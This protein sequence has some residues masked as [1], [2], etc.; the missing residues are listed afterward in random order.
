MKVNPETEPLFDGE[1]GGKKK[2]CQF[3]EKTRLTDGK[4]G[5]FPPTHKNPETEKEGIIKEHKKK[6][7]PGNNRHIW[8]GAGE[9]GI[10]EAHTE[11]YVVKIQ[12]QHAP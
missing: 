9:G 1:E 4:I 3:R 6:E 8:W 12:V 11:R 10:R 5:T 7:E 2:E